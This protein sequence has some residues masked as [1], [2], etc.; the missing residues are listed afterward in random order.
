MKKTYLPPNY[1]LLFRLSMQPMWPVVLHKF[2]LKTIFFC[3]VW[4]KGLVRKGDN[5]LTRQKIE[6]SSKYQVSLAFNQPKILYIKSRK[7]NKPRKMKIKIIKNQGTRDSVITY[8]TFIVGE[9]QFFKNQNLTGF[10]VFLMT[11]NIIILRQESL[12]R[13]LIWFPT[14]VYK[15]KRN[16]HFSKSHHRIKVQDNWGGGGGGFVFNG[17]FICFM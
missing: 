14:K 5:M 16:D 2:I 8:F 7:Q 9:R 17:V 11:V 3:H 13:F 12:K 1:P 4:Q 10:L 6:I 15:N